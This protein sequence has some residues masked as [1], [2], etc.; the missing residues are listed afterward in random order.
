[1]WMWIPPVYVYTFDVYENGLGQLH[2][3]EVGG[4]QDECTR[5]THSRFK[6]LLALLVVDLRLRPMLFSPSLWI[7][8]LNPIYVLS[9]PM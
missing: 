1:M 7:S 8:D 4:N 2:L 5:C 9:G 6:V 3:S